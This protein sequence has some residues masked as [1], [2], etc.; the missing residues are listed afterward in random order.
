MTL[1]DEKYYWA[2]AAE[3][4]NWT[5]WTKLRM[6]QVI[7]MVQPRP[8]DKILD[9]GCATGSV[10]HFCSKFGAEVTGVDFSE[11]AIQEAEK[12]HCGSK[13]TNFLV[14][15][16][17]NLYGLENSYFDK[18][19]ALDLVEH[20]YDDVFQRMLSEVHRVL[21]K[22]GTISIY[23]PSSSHIFERL[24][25]KNFILK[26]PPVHVAVRSMQQIVSALKQQG[27]E[28]DMSYFT[29]S[30]FPGFKWFELLMQPIPL[31]GD[32]FKY[33]ICVRGVK[34]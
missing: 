5:P 30:H 21:K 29:I 26:Q 27:F 25:S 24:K 14:R 18:A 22:G 31:W 8:G 6:A 3:Y 23:T 33:R 2:M 1:Y 17:A 9:L 32:L 28:I 20:L 10:V 13:N 34:V 4:A 7:K 12:L 15:D 11:L 16:V 19:V